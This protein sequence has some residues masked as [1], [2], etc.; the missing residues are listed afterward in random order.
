[1]ARPSD[2]A[3][4]EPV[5]QRAYAPLLTEASDAL[6]FGMEVMGRLFLTG[7]SAL[8]IPLKLARR[9]FRL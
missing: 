2:P 1:V 4:R 6:V 7:F 3:P 8:G 9:L 5:E